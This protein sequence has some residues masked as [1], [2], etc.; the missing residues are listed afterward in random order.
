MLTHHQKISFTIML[1]NGSRLYIAILVSE[2]NKRYIDT[3]EFLM[4]HEAASCLPG[5][6]L[7]SMSWE[8]IQYCIYKQSRKI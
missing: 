8:I 4:T 2:A 1:Q 3:E 7:V 5:L 6:F